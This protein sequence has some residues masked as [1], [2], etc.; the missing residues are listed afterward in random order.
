[1]HS[2]RQ[3]LANVSLAFDGLVCESSTV[4]KKE[5]DGGDQPKIV[6]IIETGEM[7]DHA[8]LQGAFVNALS[9]LLILCC[10]GLTN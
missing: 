6:K 10:A 1:L 5:P 2:N 7:E 3:S 4:T 9:E 8:C